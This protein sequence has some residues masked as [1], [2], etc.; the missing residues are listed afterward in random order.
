MPTVC[1]ITLDATE[2][3]RELAA[4]VAESREAAGSLSNLP[5]K[6]V[7]VTADTRQ[8]KDAVEELAKTAQEEINVPVTTDPAPLET[9][10]DALQQTDVSARKTGGILSKLI[11]ES[12]RSKAVE[13]FGAIRDEMNKTQGGAGKFLETF[14]A[15]GGAIG[16]LVGG[17]LGLGKVVSTVYN[18]WINGMKDAGE[19]AQQNAE[20]IRETAEANEQVRQKT[21]GYLSRLSELSTAEQLSNSNKAEALKLISDLRKS[22][23]DLGI[24]LDETTGKLSGVDEAMVK[25][26]QRDKDQRIRE[27][28]TELKQLQSDNAAQADV[29]DN[30]GVKVWGF[31]GQKGGF[32][33]ELTFGGEADIKEA[34]QKIAENAKRMMELR[35]QL[36]ELRRTDSV[37]DYRAK[38]QAENE[39][40]EDA[41]RERQSSFEQSKSD[42]AFSTA[43]D[44]DTKLANRRQAIDAERNGRKRAEAF[45]ALESAQT[46]YQKATNTGNQDGM[47]D[48][49]KRILQAK[50]TILASD[51]KIH[52]LEQQVEALIRQRSD[53]YKKLTDQAKYEVDYNKLIISGEFEKAA[54][55]KLEQEL[56]SQNLK[57]TQEEK[58]AI[59]EQRAALQ[60]QEVSQQIEAAKEEVALQQLLIDGNYEAYQVE[61]LR[62]EMKRQ[63]KTLTEEETRAIL[64]QRRKLGSQNLQRNLQDQA[65]S[66]FGQAMSRAGRGREFE[67]QKA[68]RD[69]ERTKGSALSSEERELVSRL[70]AASFSLSTARDMQLG[71]TS[72]RTNALTARGGFAGGAKLPETDKIN[73]EIATTGKQQLEQMKTITQ[74]CEKLGSF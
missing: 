14:L 12:L 29:R 17:V 69:A 11:P 74:I 15:G 3:R 37:A 5:D 44:F 20:S 63:G 16:I 72:I 28:E 55:L 6:K 21:D 34:G 51:E 36:G 53:A 58:N 23:G 9:A 60:R 73:R 49:E 71:D 39:D 24:V 48:A 19:L 54:A 8:A 26:L 42:E 66:L 33:S 18:N 43:L 2:Y 13:A 27:L 64:E 32:F 40:L 62:L 22:Y 61:K 10:Q 7:S 41:Y 57:L 50:Q 1:K 47:L 25:K 68:L 38:R 65:Y 59:L 70:A 67:E 35:R 52:A 30:A 4:V 45:A 31:R 56:K 46:D